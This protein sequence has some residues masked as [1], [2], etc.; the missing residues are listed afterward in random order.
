MLHACMCEV[1]C[2][3]VMTIILIDLIA[4]KLLKGFGLMPRAGFIR[5]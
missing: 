2:T 3:S 4:A 1:R 5:V